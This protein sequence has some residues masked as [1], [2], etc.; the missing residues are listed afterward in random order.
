MMVQRMAKKIVENIVKG[1]KR[2]EKS[3]EQW[4]NGER[5]GRLQTRSE[6]EVKCGIREAIKIR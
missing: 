5:G 4:K 1:K 6:A 2:R 3:A